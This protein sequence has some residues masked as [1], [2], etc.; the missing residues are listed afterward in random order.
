MSRQLQIHERLR[1]F[2]TEQ[3]AA[4]HDSDLQ[5]HGLRPNRFEIFDRAMGKQL[6]RSRPGT[7]GTKGYDPVAITST[8]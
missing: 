3:A 5:L 4:D 8:S 7:G 1:R 6:A 2:E